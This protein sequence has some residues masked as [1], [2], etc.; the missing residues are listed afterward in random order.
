MP[1]AP[2]PHAEANYNI[3]ALEDDTF[4]V[5][6]TIP[7]SKLTKVTGFATRAKAEAWIERHRANVATGTL[8]T[9]RSFARRQGKA[10]DSAG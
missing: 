5:E 7:D 10:G 2:H 1:K 9:Y 8:K 6:V 4:A 3:I